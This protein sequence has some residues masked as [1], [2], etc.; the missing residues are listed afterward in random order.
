MWP[1]IEG[2]LRRGSWAGLRVPRRAWIREVIMV[3]LLTSM[4]PSPGGAAA[5][6]WV[7]RDVLSE[8]AATVEA[9][10]RELGTALYGPFDGEWPV[11]SV[12]AFFREDVDVAA[13]FTEVLARGR[14]EAREAVSQFVVFL[15][16]LYPSPERIEFAAETHRSA[17]DVKGAF[18]G[19]LGNFEDWIPTMETLRS[20]AA[21]DGLLAELP[22][23]VTE[24]EARRLAL[25]FASQMRRVQAALP[26]ILEE[27]YDRRRR[28]GTIGSDE[29]LGLLLQGLAFLQKEWGT[30]ETRAAA[31]AN[32]VKVREARGLPAEVVGV[33]A[34][35]NLF[36]MGIARYE[37]GESGLPVEGRVL[38][39]GVRRVALALTAEATTELGPRDICRPGPCPP[40]DGFE[41]AVALLANE[42]PLAEET[43]RRVF[44]LY[45][46][47]LEG[48]C[49]EKLNLLYA[50]PDDPSLR[51][52]EADVGARVLKSLAGLVEE[53]ELQCGVLARFDVDVASVPGGSSDAALRA[54]RLISSIGEE[55]EETLALVERLD[56]VSRGI[57]DGVFE[58]WST[59]R[60][61]KARRILEKHGWLEPDVAAVS[62]AQRA[63]S[64]LG[65]SPNRGVGVAELCTG[66]I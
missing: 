21:G 57:L 27:E 10:L 16:P 46:G 63:E 17:E 23:S 59:E 3:V 53:V 51:S 56:T 36:G 19:L 7:L 1:T 6:E 66:R 54:R 37:L 4:T 26:E 5:S 14:P 12:G 13:W 60:F 44:D 45:C 18:Q 2:S 49:F 28:A 11:D 29:V 42:R 30:E 58:F 55:L 22:E 38:P 47:S 52:I 62:S 24:N 50:G 41:A 25:V 31:W 48:A 34:P 32:W 33:E 35:W 64:R 43:G 15:I 20:R 9:A 61:P 65:L 39:L 40:S 8:D